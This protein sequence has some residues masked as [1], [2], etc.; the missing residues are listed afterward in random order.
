MLAVPHTRMTDLAVLAHR[1]D[2]QTGE[3]ELGVSG[4]RKA[5]EA[6]E[7]FKMGQGKVSGKRA[8]G[9]V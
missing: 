6:V 5:R 3:K 7:E 4:V 2:D 8:K 9:K 1:Q